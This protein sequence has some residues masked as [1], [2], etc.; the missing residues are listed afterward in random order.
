LNCRRAELL[1]AFLLLAGCG[2]QSSLPDVIALNTEPQGARYAWQEGDTWRFLAW[3]ILD[4]DSGEGFNA[5]ALMAGFQP[6]LSPR[7]GETIELPIDQSMSDAL[8]NRMDSAR[9][10]RDA[11]AARD[12][13]LDAEALVLLAEAVR[14]DPGWSVPAW[15]MALLQLEQGDREGAIATL[16]PVA[17]KPRVEVLLARIAWESGNSSEA[18][19]HAETALLAPEPSTEALACA[20]LIYTVTGNSYQASRL[21]LR[22]LA[23]PSARSTLRILAVRNCLVLGQ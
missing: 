14:R 7:P 15:D 22:I 1:G 20:A 13:G 12:S 21:W 8:E 2:T 19:Q 18:M 17:G 10:V 6:D 11:S 4:S 16:Q 9:L 3:A 23:D 5:L